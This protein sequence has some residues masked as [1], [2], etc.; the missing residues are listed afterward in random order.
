MKVLFRVDA[1]T[2]MGTG[3]V[4]RCRTLAHELARRGA[5]IC[6][7]CREHPGQMADVLERD[8]F[9]VCRLPPV[10]DS[11][12]GQGYEA[13][14]GVSQQ[15]DA[16]QSSAATDGQVF[17]WLVVDHYALDRS[18]EVPMRQRAQN[19]LIIDDIANRP[20]ECDVLL[21]QNSSL[22]GAERYRPWVPQSCR[23]LL[24]PRYALLRPENALHRSAMAPRAEAASRVLVYMGGSDAANITGMALQALGSPRLSH[25]EVDVVVG[26][27]FTHQ[28]QI[29]SLA[30]A[31]PGTHVLGMQPHLAEL[32]VRADIAVG[33]GGATTWER[34]C[35]GLPSL[36][37]SIAE[38]QVPGCM[39]LADAGLIR[40]FG[41]AQQM[42]VAA[43]EAALEQAI[44]PGQRN[45]D[46]RFLKAAP[47]DGLGARRIAEFLSPSPAG[48]LRLRPADAGDLDTYFVWVNDPLVRAG[49][50]RTA[51]ITMAEHG[52]WFMSRLQ[53]PEC[54]LLVLESDGLPLGQLRLERMEGG[55]NID[56]SIDT[57]F[58]GRR[59]GKKLLA[60]GIQW[61]SELGESSVFLRAVVKESNAASAKTFESL[62]FAEVAQEQSGLRHF[63]FSVRA[64]MK[65]VALHPQ[66]FCND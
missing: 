41:A 35:L 60:L 28:Q 36:V 2:V 43:M 1:S 40:Y 34:L 3:H 32:M 9:K 25:L 30:Q 4:M 57:L 39:A 65:A 17:D 22:S 45:A 51:P 11:G 37:V 14:L 27:N 24:G 15:V 64:R 20:H 10:P 49:A 13:W 56:Y 5:Q 62:G 12:T 23:L 61:I 6:F 8:G 44:E 29:V 53:A 58:R 59:W 21:D 33:A 52:A 38:N 31:R 63:Q 7:I 66:E 26:P 46:L 47:V 55:W 18:W 19:I 48:S 54:L 50:L 16:M 42:S